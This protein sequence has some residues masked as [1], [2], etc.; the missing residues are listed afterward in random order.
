MVAQIVLQSGD[1]GNGIYEK[2]KPHQ[3]KAGFPT[4]ADNMTQ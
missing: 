1:K 3:E 2:R 4:G